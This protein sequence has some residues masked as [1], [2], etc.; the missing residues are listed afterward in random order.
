M[1]GRSLIGKV[2]GT[3]GNDARA[4]AATDQADQATAAL[5]EDRSATYHEVFGVREFRYLFS[6]YLLSLIGDQLAKVALSIVVFERTGSVLLSAVTFAVGYLPW[7]LGGPLLSVY[8]DRYPRR[9]VMISCDLVR[10]V[11]VGSLAIPGMPLWSLVGLLFVSNL[12]T[13][14]FE[15]ARAAT[16]PEVL[17]GDRYAVGLALSSITAQVAQVVGFVAGG[18][19]VV[20]LSARGSLLID[21]ATFAVSALLLRIGVRRRPAAAQDDRATLWSDAKQGVRI[22]FGIPRVRWFI[23]MLFV[24][25]AL[26]Y[27]PEGLA[28]AYAVEL[29]EGPYAVGLL[30]AASPLGLIIGGVVIGR[31][32]RPSRREALLVP[33]AVLSV[34]VLIP[35]T[36]VA[37]LPGVLLL[38]FVS[39]FGVSFLIPLNVMVVRAIPASARARAFGVVA[40]G[41]QAVQ[42]V[43]I[44][45]AGLVADLLSPSAVVTLCGAVGTLAVLWLGLRGLAVPAP[46]PADAATR[47][48]RQ[49][50]GG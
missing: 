25:S 41:L 22:V 21:A 28:A 38:F 2:G 32:V 17:S 37:W 3:M 20:L 16:T 5:P 29:G 24:S 47:H 45:L 36:R 18:A 42:G 34:L 46:V 27:A 43:A 9:R 8:A 39:G 31:L 7:L 11:L 26:A 40:T 10:M 23:L 35:A 48:S 50:E 14:P 1:A 4:V 6:A 44:V 12:F 30:L 33:L 19:L 49:N 15:A 13:P